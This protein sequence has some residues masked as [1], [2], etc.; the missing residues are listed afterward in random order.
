MKKWREEL[1]QLMAES[2]YDRTPALRRSR[3]TD[4]L[5]ATDYP[6][7]ADSRCVERFLD[8]AGKNG[9]HAAI[10]KDWIYLDRQ[11]GFEAADEPSAQTPE[12]A[13]C[14]SLLQREREKTPS[15][16]STE[17]MILKALEEGPDTYEKTCAM[18]HARWAG[19]LRQKQLLPDMDKRFFGGTEK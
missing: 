14:L 4:F 13:C 18:L 1:L 11:P 16:G 12:A 19:M 10:E 5:F 7:A 2:G 6:C 8:S 9:W 3:K 15:D 17:R